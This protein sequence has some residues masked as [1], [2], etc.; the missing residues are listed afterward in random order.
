MWSWDYHAS[1]RDAALFG[2]YYGVDAEGG[3]VKPLVVV[4][5]P[6]LKV[7]DCFHLVAGGLAAEAEGVKGLALAEAEPSFQFRKRRGSQEYHEGVLDEGADGGGA[8]NVELDENVHALAEGVF[9]LLL[10]NSV[11]VAVDFGAFQELFAFPHVLEFFPVEEEV[12]DAVSLGAAAGAGGGGDDE[13]PGPVEFSHILEDGVFAD[14]G[15]A[16]HDDQQGVA[17]PVGS[18]GVRPVQG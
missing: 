4:D 11:P 18:I 8:L 12:V 3:K 6:V 9:N 13:V 1:R 15:G 16:G 5:D 14:A 2:G 10:G 7:I 17:E